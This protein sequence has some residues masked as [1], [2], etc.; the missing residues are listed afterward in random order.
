M[1]A[2]EAR[3]SG[4]RHVCHQLHGERFE[5]QREI[6]AFARPRLRGTVNGR[7]R[8]SNRMAAMLSGFTALRSTISQDALIYFASIQ[9]DPRIVS[10]Q[11]AA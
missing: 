6:G 11:R 2:D 1:L 8:A 5:Q 10:R 9:S 3:R 4:D 7:A